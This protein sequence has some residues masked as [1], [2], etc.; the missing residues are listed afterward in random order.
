LGSPSW[1]RRAVVCAISLGREV[2]EEW[3][4]TMADE[5]SSVEE[6]A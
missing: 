1:E 5:D 6:A 3:R 2:R 4:M